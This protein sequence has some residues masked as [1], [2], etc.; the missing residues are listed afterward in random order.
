M[1]IVLIKLILAHIIGDFFLQPNNWVEEKERKKFRSGKLYLHCLIHGILILLFLFD[2]SY[3]P[4]AL[5]LSIVHCVIDSLK[6]YAQKPASKRAWF[7]ADQLLHLISIFLVWQY[8]RSP[9]LDFSFL[10]SPSFWLNLTAI[11]ILTYPTSIIIKVL[12][13]RWTPDAT[14]PGSKKAD[15]SLQSAGQFIGI[16]ERLLVFAFIYTQHFEAIGFLI[17]A[18]SIFRF[19]DLKEG[20][21]LKLTEYI[22]IGTLLSFGIAMFISL[23]IIELT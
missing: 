16:I 3:W 13:A 2:I 22:L 5:L 4:V 14:H 21:D 17:A 1:D 18:K 9:V 23:L 12:I 6:L 10:N 19:G 11:L 20:K 15:T 8:I 7:F